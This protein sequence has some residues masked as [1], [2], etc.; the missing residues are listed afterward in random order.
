MNL[1]SARDWDPGIRFPPNDKRRRSDLGIQRFELSRMALVALR[2][3][4]VE[5]RLPVG[6]APRLDERLLDL[7]F[8]R[9]WLSR[10]D[11]GSEHSFMNPRRQFLEDSPVVVN[12]LV[13]R[14]P[15]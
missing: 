7:W 4:P 8:Q 2:D 12:E 6:S 3:L 1:D 5:G 14:R 13:E 15:P 9:P 10:P 11:V